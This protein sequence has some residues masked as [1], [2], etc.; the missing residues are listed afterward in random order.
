[1]AADTAAAV[2]AEAAGNPGA[3]VSGAR[4]EPMNEALY[5]PL[6]PVVH[7]L[8]NGM[9]VVCEYLPYVHSASIG[10]WIKTGSANESAELAGISHFLEHLLFKGTATRTARELMEAVEGR[11]GQLNAFTTREYTC[12]YAKTLDQHAASAFEILADIINHSTFCDLDK[13]RNVILE[14]IAS[15]QDVPD[16]YVHDVLSEF[17]W[18][19][20]PLGR[21]IA[22]YEETVAAT[23]LDHV[24]AYRDRWYT[25]E[26]MIVSI[27]GRFD[28]AIF[29]KQVED[30]FGGMCPLREAWAGGAPAFQ[31]GQRVERRDIAQDHLLWSFPSVSITHEERFAFDLLSTALGGGSTSRLFE[32]VREQEGLAYAVYSFNSMYAAGGMLGFYAAV[33]P[34]NLQHTLDISGEEMR[35]LCDEPLPEHEL[36]SNREQIKGGLL[37]ALE[38]T[39]ARMS[40]MVRSLIYRDRIVP[41]G[42]V[43]DSLDQVTAAE[44]QSIAQRTFSADRSA[45]AV[46]GPVGADAFRLRV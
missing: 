14:E 8:D 30:A 20:H 27:V 5:T 13:E 24:R 3:A 37:L 22:G 39:F 6:D 36:V 43:L 34:E 12:V 35:K 7:T 40:R 18:P 46:L 2:G 11:G 23:E 33:A 26:N 25:P 1:M 17:A 19:D 42:E 45:L 4:A 15:N 29:L 21:P 16:D 41:V 9:R 10:V 32:R 44:I 28:E 31:P 38:S